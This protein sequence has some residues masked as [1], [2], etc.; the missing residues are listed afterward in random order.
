MKRRNRTKEVTISDMYCVECANK[1]I[2]IPRISGQYRGPAHLKRLFCIHCGKETNHMEI[3]PFGSYILEDF[4]EEFELGRFVNGER[5]PVSELESCKKVDCKYNKSG[6]CWNANKSFLCEK[7]DIQT[8][9]LLNK[10]W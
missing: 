4:E 8:Q 2:S 9:N 1:G 7:R 10:G 5:I 6:K 3:R